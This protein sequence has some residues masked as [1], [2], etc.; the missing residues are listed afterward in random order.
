LQIT[1]GRTL[2]IL[3]SPFI[4][5]AI[6]IAILLNTGIIGL[7]T[8]H[9]L[10]AR[11]SMAVG[12]PVDAWL[13]RIS[14]WLV[15]AFLLENAVRFWAMG[16]DYLRDPWSLFDVVVLGGAFL[17]ETSYLSAL[18]VLRVLPLL[19]LLSHS[20][21]LRLI[22]SV[23]VRAFGGCVAITLLMLMVMYVFAVVGCALYGESNPD[24]FGNLHLGMYTLFTAAAAYHV[25]EV[26]SAI[27][28]HHPGV[29]W[30]LLP[31][32]LLMSLVILNLFAG[33]ITFLLYE[34]SFE[35]IRYGRRPYAPNDQAPAS[36]S[37]PGSPLLARELQVLRE[38]IALLRSEL[39]LRRA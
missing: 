11:W 14:F 15:V 1:R 16:R 22:V 21:S 9:A 28:V 36:G 3:K 17:G 29:Y 5:I 10:L 37:A 8:Y 25:D 7:E 4:R 18:R 27:A 33:I 6:V 39:A 2:I 32:F 30:F 35:E 38:E 34:L 23:I 31:Y 19:A 26:A 24:L 12:I 20:G 13:E